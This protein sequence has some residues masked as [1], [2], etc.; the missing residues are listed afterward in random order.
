MGLLLLAALFMWWRLSNLAKAHVSFS[1]LRNDFDHMPAP[2]TAS[3]TGHTG[4]RIQD[5]SPPPALVLLIAFHCT[6]LLSRHSVNSPCPA[7]SSSRPTL[8][9]LHSTLS[10]A[11]LQSASSHSFCLCV[12]RVLVISMRGD[13]PPQ[14]NVTTGPALG[15]TASL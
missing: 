11:C 12:I 2:E 7:L 6:H 8:S 3:E 10:S 1:V 13:I 5:H 9:S 15:S 4:M 14:P